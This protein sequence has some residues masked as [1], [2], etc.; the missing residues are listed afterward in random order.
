MFVKTILSLEQDPNISA[1]IFAWFLN[2]DKESLNLIKRAY[3]QMTKPF[4]CVSY[5]I[6]D[7]VEYYSQKLS[8]KKSLLKLKV[9][10][11]ESIELMARSLDKYCRFK[12]FI[13]K[14]K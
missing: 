7:D 12:E 6:A 9:P 13:A 8:F 3:Y 10:V 4:I 14:H 1:I 2:F 11:Y 5:K